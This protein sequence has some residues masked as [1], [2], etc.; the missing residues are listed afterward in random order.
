MAPAALIPS[1]KPRRKLHHLTSSSRTYYNTFQLRTRLS[2]L[3]EPV[4]L[5]NLN[6]ALK[7]RQWNASPR[8]RRNA[9]TGCAAAVV[10]VAMSSLP[11][12]DN[13]SSG[14]CVH[15]PQYLRIT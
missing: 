4:R 8:R 3:H 15:T 2:T 10:V 14:P 1:A 12:D 9:A 6:A 13:L 11:D 7:P 5:P